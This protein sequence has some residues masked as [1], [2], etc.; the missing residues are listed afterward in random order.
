MKNITALECESSGDDRVI[1]AF[2]EYRFTIIPV[3]IIIKSYY[4]MHCLSRLLCS[5][6]NPTGVYCR[7]T[8]QRQKA[9]SAY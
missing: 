7:S 6:Q 2:F 4:K 3:K 5:G 9:V 1:V 8:L